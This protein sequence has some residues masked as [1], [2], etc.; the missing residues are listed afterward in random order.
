MKTRILFS[1][2]GAFQIQDLNLTRYDGDQAGRHRAYVREDLLGVRR[3]AKKHPYNQ[4]ICVPTSE[5]E[6]I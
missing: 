4:G 2:G 5:D 3:P 6:Q 1:G